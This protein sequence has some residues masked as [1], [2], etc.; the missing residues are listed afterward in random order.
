PNA[1]AFVSLAS[2]KV[3]SDM[4]ASNLSIQETLAWS[5]LFGWGRYKPAKPVALPL[6]AVADRVGR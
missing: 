5:G 2:G 6:M 1:A 3:R 4:N